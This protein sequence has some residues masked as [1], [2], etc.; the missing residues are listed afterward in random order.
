MVRHE[1]RRPTN[2]MW[3]FCEGNTE[4]NYFRKV[5]AVEKISRLR[6]KVKNCDKYTSALSILKYTIAY[7]KYHSN[8]FE[9]DDIIFCVFDRDNN[10]EDTLKK[11]VKLA[12]ENGISIIFSNPSFEYWILCHFGYFPAAFENRDLIKKLKKYMPDYTKT[13]PEIYIK[14]KDKIDDALRNAARIKDKHIAEKISLISRKSNPIS[15][16]FELIEKL[17]EFRD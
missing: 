15:L 6:I 10:A 8:S 5:Y 1:G 16:V 9:K 2:T 11:A 14:T 17:N 3:I 4:R 13:D 7:K 12:G